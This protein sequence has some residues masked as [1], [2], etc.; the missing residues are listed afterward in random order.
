M[1]VRGLKQVSGVIPTLLTVSDTVERVNRG[2]VPKL[3]G[4]FWE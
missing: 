3:I 2:N 1:R 4:F